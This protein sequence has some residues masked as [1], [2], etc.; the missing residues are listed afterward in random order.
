MI[1]KA[2]LVAALLALAGCGG[3]QHEDVVEYRR[4]NA[5]RRARTVPAVPTHTARVEALEDT[6]D[7]TLGRWVDLTR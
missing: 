3:V 4:L 5:E 7:T 6:L 1:K 2:L